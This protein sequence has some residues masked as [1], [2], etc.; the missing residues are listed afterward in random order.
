MS[1]S[2][3]VTKGIRAM[4][5]YHVPRPDGIRAKL[6]ANELPN[7]LP[8]E[9]A[10]ALG[11]ELAQVALNRYPEADPVELRAIVAAD[12]G[13]PPGQLV[14]GNGS[15]ELIALLCATFAE[16]RP[17]KT[18]ASILYP[19]PTF[20]VYRLAALAHKLEAIEIT[21][22]DE[23]QLDFELV[24]DAL[25]G[26]QPNIAFFALPNNPTGTLW[27]PEKV[28]ELAA[29]HPG[30]IF[31]SDEAYIQ[32]GGRTLLPRLPDLPNLVVMR[33]MSKIGMASLRVGFVV[34]S[35]AIVHELEKLRMPYNLGSLNQRA[36]VWL[37]K[38][39][40]TWMAERARELLVER[41]RLAAALRAFP[42]LKVFPSEANLLLVR[43][44]KANDGAATRVWKALAAK[45]IMVRNFDRPGPLAGCLRITPG[46]PAEDELLLAE[47]P[48][49]IATATT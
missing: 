17:G 31:V 44:G 41:E 35:P 8:P 12:L 18:H 43:V 6:D 15:D 2:D 7:S 9:A 32:Y 13:V 26:R 23:M 48:A 29:R 21:L 4:A 40:K 33:T 47:L 10:E 5:A 36:A 3:L 46:T 25:G 20:V 1:I 42:E 22:D 27:A 37:L 24:D 19:D 49:A 16:P 34:A 45:G 11:R 14:F 30:T 39:H 28:A 38:H